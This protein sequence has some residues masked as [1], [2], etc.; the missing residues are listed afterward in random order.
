[1]EGLLARSPSG[2]T[3]YFKELLY[4]YN[5]ASSQEEPRY[6]NIR[7]RHNVVIDSDLSLLW[8]W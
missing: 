2:D 7:M 8:E 6:A 1:M 4:V 3:M 5:N